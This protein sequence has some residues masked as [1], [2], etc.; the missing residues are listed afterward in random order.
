MQ[1]QHEKR[2]WSRAEHWFAVNDPP[3]RLRISVDQARR[4]RWREKGRDPARLRRSYYM[5]RLGYC[6]L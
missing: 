3:N 1:A 6:R 2:R 5:R 4:T